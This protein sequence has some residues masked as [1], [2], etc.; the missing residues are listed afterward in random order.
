M[1]LIAWLLDSDPA[2]RW[3]TRWYY[4]LLRALDCFRSTGERP[5]ERVAEAIEPI[6]AKQDAD[7]RWPL[8]NVH[9]GPT[10]FEMERPEGAPSRWNTLRALRVLRWAGGAAP[11]PGILG[12]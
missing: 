6:A 5:D 12:R 10:H 3:P 7:G 1:S 2:I 9:Q 4:D 8:E 11:R